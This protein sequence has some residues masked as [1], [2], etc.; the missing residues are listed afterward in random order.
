M[1]KIHL[2]KVP[3][4]FKNVNLC[5]HVHVTQKKIEGEEGVL[6]LVEVQNSV[7]KRAVIESING[8]LGTLYTGDVIPVVLGFRQ[9][10][11]EYAGIIPH[12]IA[13]G[14]Q[15]FLLGESGVAGTI[16]SIFPSW[17]EPLAVKVLGA[18]VNEQ[19]QLINLSNFALPIIPKQP[20][21]APIVAFI[22]TR[23]DCGKTTMACNVVHAFKKRGKKIAAGKLTGFSYAG[24]LHRLRDCGANPVLNFVDMGMPSTCNAQPERV[25][26]SAIN[27]VNHLKLSQPDLIVLEFGDSLLG[28]YHV[29]DILQKLGK[30]EMV[31]I[32]VLAAYDFCGIKGAQSVLNEL[33]LSID[34]VTGPV[35]NSQIGVEL[36]QKYFSLLAESNQG[37]TSTLVNL[38]DRR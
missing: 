28:E 1:D 23:M 13:V 2:D 4:I 33:G 17:G 7:G 32:V 10:L 14:E 38:I 37:E 12:S 36:V 9:A 5:S 16:S 22:G 31:D 26:A 29:A 30:E 19:G 21:H 15:L 24:D 27:L 18:I 11:V 34:L 35:V 20:H 3:S 25:V 6:L 8:R